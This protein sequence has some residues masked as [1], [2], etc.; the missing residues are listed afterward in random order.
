MNMGD[1][2]KLV[3]NRFAYCFELLGAKNAEYAEKDDKLSNFK[4]AAA[5]KGETPE[6]ALWGMYCKHIIS[7]KKIIEDIESIRLIPTQKMIAEK[8]SDIINY[9]LL[10]EALI[11]ERRRLSEE[12]KN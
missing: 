1:F 8:I 12:N 9:A 5:L 2:I 11:Q 7:L 4:Q 10:F 3:D 6:S